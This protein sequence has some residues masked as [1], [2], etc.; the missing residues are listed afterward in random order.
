MRKLDKGLA[1]L[2]SI[3]LAL[4]IWP[5][6]FLDL[7]GSIYIIV[8]SVFL[9]SLSLILGLTIFFILRNVPNLRT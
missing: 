6:N 4:I 3:V 7:T 2:V 1:T 8:G 5:T 9:I